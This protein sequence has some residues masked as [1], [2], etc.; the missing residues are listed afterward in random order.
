MRVASVSKQVMNY[1]LA[2]IFLISL[3]PFKTRTGI[4]RTHCGILYFDE[5]RDK[6]NVRCKF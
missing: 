6:G 4:K 5:K 1:V 2:E 3:L